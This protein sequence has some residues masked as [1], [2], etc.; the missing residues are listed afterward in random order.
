MKNT[1]F[2][3]AAV[4]IVTPFDDNYKVDYKKLAEIID[5]QIE[6]S[7]DAIVICGTTGEGSTLDHEEHAKAVKFAC[8]Y[9]NKRVPVIAGTGSNDTAY[10]VITTR[11][12]RWVLS[13]TMSLLT[14]E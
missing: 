9:T 7:T 5:Y 12:H 3:G 1:V 6:N 13:N 11:H 10:A 14:T 2:T 4:A 8:E